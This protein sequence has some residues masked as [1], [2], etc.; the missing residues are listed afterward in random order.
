VHVGR[1]AKLIHVYRPVC[2]SSGSA[3]CSM[4]L[5]A[6]EP[7]SVRWIRLDVTIHSPESCHLS[8]FDRTAEMFGGMIARL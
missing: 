6:F 1:F 3:M 5:L 8:N 7:S 4:P 2:R